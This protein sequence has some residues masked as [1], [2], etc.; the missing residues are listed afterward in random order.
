MAPS[1]RLEDVEEGASPAEHDSQDSAP[2]SLPF[3]MRS[4]IPSS[5]IRLDQVITPYRSTTEE[6]V[7]GVTSLGAAYK[8]IRTAS[9]SARLALV[10]HSAN[11][12]GTTSITNP[13]IS[14]MW[15]DAASPF[16][17]AL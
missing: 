10:E 9:I 12:I 4:A 1:D 8:V 15:G 11:G 3:Q 17:Y 14:G 7:V 5:S 6:G 16:R 2:Y 13:V